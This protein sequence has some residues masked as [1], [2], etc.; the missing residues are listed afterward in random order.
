VPAGLVDGLPV[1]LMVAGPLYKEER[2]LQVAAAF[3]AA[4]EWK[5]KHPAL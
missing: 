3:E 5:S 4:T 2:V 1:G